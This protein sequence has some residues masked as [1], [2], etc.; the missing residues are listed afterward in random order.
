MFSL[1]FP[2]LCPIFPFGLYPNSF[3]SVCSVFSLTLNS[4]LFSFVFSAHFFL[5]HPKPCICTH[6]LPLSSLFLKFNLPFLSFALSEFFVVLFYIT[7]TATTIPQDTSFLSDVLGIIA[8]CLSVSRLKSLDHCLA[9][10]FD[11]I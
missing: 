9:G 11:F 5:S 4:S 1:Y 2:S 6:L 7:A 3:S 10:R 8:V